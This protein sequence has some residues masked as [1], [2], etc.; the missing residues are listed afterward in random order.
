MSLTE[1]LTIITLMLT[2]PDKGNARTRMRKGKDTK[3][4]EYRRRA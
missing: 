3:F 4:S 1:T 2:R